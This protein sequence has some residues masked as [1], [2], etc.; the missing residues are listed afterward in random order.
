MF[1]TLD[2]GNGSMNRDLRAA[3][4]S[5]QHPSIRF[6]VSRLDLESVGSGRLRVETTGRLII[7][8]VER[9]VSI[10]L[11]GRRHSDGHIRSN[12]S[13]PLTLSSF[14]I[15]PPTALLGLVKVHDH[16]VVHFDLVEPAADAMAVSATN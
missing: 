15:D 13:T 14:G 3:L 7:A 1:R 12:G 2:C 10:T 11:D 5:E 9:E 6:E 8:G 16:V 4:R